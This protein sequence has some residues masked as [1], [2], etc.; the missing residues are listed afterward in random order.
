[1]QMAEKKYSVIAKKQ[2]VLNFI[3]TVSESIK[4]VM[5]ATVWDAIT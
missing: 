4:H 1:M 5:A 2:N 3:V